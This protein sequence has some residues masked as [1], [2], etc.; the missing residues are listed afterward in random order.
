MPDDPRIPDAAVIWRRISP[1]QIVPDGDGERISSAAFS[2]SSDSPMSAT[3]EAGRTY[4]E[5]LADY[6][7]FG[8]AEL[9]VRQVRSLGEAYDVV[10]DPQPDDPHHVLVK[11]KKT[12]GV[13][14][15]LAGW[16][17]LRR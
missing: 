9:T 4:R 7:G 10:R 15:K 3:L 17:T 11:G 12:T 8:L 5:A 14:K 6:Q 13:R 1:A 16:S 2:D